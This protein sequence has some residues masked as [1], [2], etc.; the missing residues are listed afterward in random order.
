[1]SAGTGFMQAV[2]P[3]PYTC[4]LVVATQYVA[5]FA[6]H[7]ADLIMRQCGHRF[8]EVVIC[9][10]NPEKELSEV[11]AKAGG[12]GG[13]KV[14][15]VLQ[16][17]VG[18]LAV[19]YLCDDADKPAEE[20]RVVWIHSLS[21]GLDYYYFFN[22]PQLMENIPITNG[23]R[24]QSRALAEHVMYAIGYFNRRTWEWKQNKHAH[25]W[26]KY[27]VQE[28]YGQK[29]V[30]LG[31]GDIGEA[32]AKLAV[33]H[34]MEV[35]AVKRSLPDSQESSPYVDRFGVKVYAEH[36]HRHRHHHHDN[37]EGEA[38]AAQVD[39]EAQKRHFEAE[40]A[41][42]IAESDYV[43]NIMPGTPET[44][45]FFNKAVFATMKKTAIYVNVGRGCTNDEADLIEAL[46]T[47]TIRGA[48]LDVFEVEPLSADS[49]L[50]E[51]PDE[52]LMITC[53]SAAQTADQVSALTARFVSLCD[54]WQAGEEIQSEEINR[55]FWY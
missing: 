17:P 47:D 27:G 5:G 29:M 40:R 18:G 14:V 48:A 21:V 35:E 9:E 41:R 19:Q 45:K 34:G 6:S 39:A 46:N 28:M 12:K 36:K 33:A 54:R 43:V 38:Q 11:K 7:V 23:K 26:A 15:M 53:H 10:A 3:N 51:M 25:R 32:T 2:A 30:I 44:M 20:R 50:W 55:Q 8:H 31:Y 49:P 16:G 4:T 1:M 13:K 22:Y 24:S 37:H 52:K 42:M